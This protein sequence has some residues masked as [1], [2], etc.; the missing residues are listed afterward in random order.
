MP[1]PCVNI[2]LSTYNDTDFIEQQIQSLQNQIGVNITISI[3]DDG[4]NERTRELLIKITQK[5]NNIELNQS[6]NIG[7]PDSFFSLMQQ[8]ETKNF[9]YYAF[10][11]QDD[12]WIPEKLIVAIKK[13]Q[14]AKSSI[15]LYCSRQTYIDESGNIISDSFTPNK[16]L[17][18]KNA[19]LE[20]IAVG[21]TCV[22]TPELLKIATSPKDYKNIIM[23]DWWVYLTATA[24][25]EVIFD[26]TPHTLYRQHK[27][28][29]IGGNLKPLDKF[30]S[31]IKK[32][33]QLKNQ[34]KGGPINQIEKLFQ[35]YQEQLPPT[36]K[37]LITELLNTFHEG[38]IARVLGVINDKLFY[39]QKSLEHITWKF[40]FIFKM[41]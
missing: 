3:R 38:I 8:Q 30:K 11:D 41:L 17:G 4:S 28:N 13:L 24:L 27:N 31:R 40:L 34:Q 16:P 36:E 9:D 5:H 39:R 25:G 6:D 29:V 33:Q 18:L 37:K 35:Q 19:M 32:Y 2:L 23:H 14:D 12:I 7:L 20:N 10:C 1:L 22:F 15:A 26:Q 21:C